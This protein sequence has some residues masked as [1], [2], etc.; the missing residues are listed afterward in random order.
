M[1][2]SIPATT[3]FGPA[4]LQGLR[5]VKYLYLVWGAL[6]RRPART[7]LTVMSVTTAFFLFGVLQGINVGIDNIFKVLNV[8]HLDVMSRVSMNDPLPLAHVSRIGALPGVADATPLTAVVGTY[9]RPTDLQ[10]VLGVDTDAF[11]RIYKEIKVSPEQVEALRRTRSGAIVGKQ[12]AKKEG[13]KIGDRIPIHSFNAIKQDGSADWVFDLVAIYD[14]DQTDWATRFFV[15]YDYVNEALKTG[16][17]KVVQVLV[18][19]KDPSQSAQVSQAIDDLFANSPNQTVT[20]N[21]KDYVESLM[22][23]IGDI[24]FLVNGIVGAVLFTLLFLTANTMAQSV[25]ERVPELAV[26]K[27]LGFSDTAVQRLVLAESL[28]VCVI[29]ALLGLAIASVVLPAIAQLLSSQGIGPLRVA[30]AVL[31]AGV[32]TAVVLA[33][34]SGL[35]PALRARRLDIVAALAGR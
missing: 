28:I 9:Q 22:R 6:R 11:L 18:G 34:V 13:W 31:A 35:L 2:Q 14:L 12:L 24:S 29:S 5:R 30:P 3:G 32:V 26:L 1:Q 10:V 19:I 15:H 21:E 7:L 20:Q 4:P 25:R 8:A 16:K 33:L 17:D 23:Q 27:T